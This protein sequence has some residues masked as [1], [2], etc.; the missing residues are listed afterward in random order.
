MTAE[1]NDVFSTQWA[2][3][4]QQNRIQLVNLKTK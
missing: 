1:L 4:R 3:R 2:G